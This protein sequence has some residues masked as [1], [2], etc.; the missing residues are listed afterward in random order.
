MVY[1]TSYESGR[2]P[3]VP[4]TKRGNWGHPNDFIYA[5]VSLAFRVDIFAMSWFLSMDVGSK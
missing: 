5:G 2:Q 4:D 1:E 3:F